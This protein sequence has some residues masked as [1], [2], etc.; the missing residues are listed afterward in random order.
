ME[1]RERL[2][3]VEKDSFSA[4]LQR[5]MVEALAPNTLLWFT[6]LG[7]TGIWGYV[8]MDPQPYKLIAAG[9]YSALVYIPML[10]WRRR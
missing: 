5:L 3:I 2:Q 1:P 7:V 8:A 9:A 6:T 4:G 10:I